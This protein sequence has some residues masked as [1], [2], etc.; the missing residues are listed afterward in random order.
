VQLLCN[1]LVSRLN[2]LIFDEGQEREP[3]IGVKDVEAVL[4]EDFFERGNYYFSGV[5]GQATENERHILQVM[6]GG[7]DAWSLAELQTVAELDS[8][9]LETALEK[10]EQHDVLMRESDE[11]GITRWRF[12]VPL[13]QQWVNDI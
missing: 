4:Q 5:W 7:T 6:A 9:A 12:Q 13:M 11:N 10:L 3:R 2:H 1:C 8:A